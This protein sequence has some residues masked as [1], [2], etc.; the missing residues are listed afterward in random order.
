MPSNRFPM[1]NGLKR[2][3]NGPELKKLKKQLLNGEKPKCCQACWKAEASGM[4]THRQVESPFPSKTISHIHLRI[5][6][7]CNYKC[8]MC[9]PNFSSTWEVENR[10]HNYFIHKYSTIKDSIASDPSLLPFI[11]TLA[12][13]GQLKQLNISGGEPLLS[14]AN[15]KLLNYLIDN[16]LTDLSI[17]YSTNLSKL[18]YKGYDLLE[19]WS[20]FSKVRLDVSCDGWGEQN[21]YGRTGFDRKDFMN[22]FVKALRHIHGINCVVNMY[23]VW[24]LPELYKIC[25]HFNKRVYFSPCFLPE[26]LNPQRLPPEEKHKLRELYK[27]IPELEYVY[28]NYIAKDLTPIMHKFISYNLMLDKHRGTD[29]FNTFPMYKKYWTNNI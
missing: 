5:S 6:N 1:G 3:M 26:Y 9:N 29:L 2:Y 18:N 24:S 16:K 7:V 25:K 23:S 10:K 14:D 15:I 21:E 20:N 27:G 17:A 22:N 12:R 4:D 8:R 28:E 13:L 19:A 11:G